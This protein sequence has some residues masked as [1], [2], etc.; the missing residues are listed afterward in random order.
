MKKIRQA[1]ILAGGLGK[2][3]HPL[4][5]T[6]PKPMIKI[7]GKPFLAYLIEMLKKNGIEEVLLL[8]GYLHE[9]IENYF[10]EGED[11]GLKIIY[12][13]SPVEAQTGTR[14]RNAKKLIHTNFLLMYADNYWPLALHTLSE[15][16]WKMNRMGTITV[17]KNLDGYTKNNI[18]IDEDGL[19]E[20]YD[21][22]KLLENLTG[23]DIGFFIFNKKVLNYLPSENCWF[24]TTVIPSLIKEKQLAAY[25]THHKYYGLSN[26]ERIP[27][28][29]EF[30]KDKKVVFLD[31]DGV[32]NKKAPRAKY[33]TRW[34]EFVFLP[35]AK[36]ALKILKKKGYKIFILT[37]QPGIA[38][39][40]M[41]E[42]SLNDIH[43]KMQQ[44]LAKNGRT[45]DDIF[46][47]MHGWNDAC[48]CRKPK[49]GMFFQAAEKYHINL[50]QTY[51]IGDD[52]RDMIA[53]TAAGVRS[54]RVDGKFDLYTIAD[55]YL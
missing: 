32:I 52:E 38:R 2:R 26:L 19:V 30:F 14:I 51:C 22:R 50:F 6:T 3:L 53:A 29:E 4:T 47:C 27:V 42:A 33:I 17:Y 35:K 5:L 10:K 23:V 9:Q 13:H 15:H 12:S 55:R 34:E 8:V 45:I 24:E 20:A 40:I 7:H 25:V 21:K 37:N 31:R 16:H 18:K 28:I 43:E 44:E 48:F 46:V 49:P 36:K 11:F 1:V 54:F 39:G 41:T